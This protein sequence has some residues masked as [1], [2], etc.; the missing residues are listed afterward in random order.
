MQ[1]RQALAHAAHVLSSGYFSHAFAHISHALAHASQASIAIGP[2]FAHTVM[3]ILQNSAQSRHT[4]IQSAMSL[5]PWAACSLQWAAHFRHSSA[6]LAHESQ[7]SMQHSFMSLGL[8][9]AETCPPPARITAPAP[10]PVRTSRRFMMISIL[11]DDA[12]TAYQ[13]STRHENPLPAIKRGLQVSVSPVP[14]RREQGKAPCEGRP[15]PRF[16]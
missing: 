5:C 14:S 1:S 4:F 16:P 2:T 8:S 6:H 12:P 9:S 13:R 11:G 7:Q 3:H 10:I 15:R